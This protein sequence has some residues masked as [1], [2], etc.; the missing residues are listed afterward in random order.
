MSKTKNA[1]SAPLSEVLRSLVGKS[2]SLAVLYE[3]T[4]TKYV[5][6]PSRRAARL[7]LCENI[8]ELYRLLSTIL[9][10]KEQRKSTLPP[11]PP[12]QSQEQRRE[13]KTDQCKVAAKLCCCFRILSKGETF[14][15]TLR[16]CIF[17]FFFFYSSIAPEYFVKI[18]STRKLV[19]IHCILW[20]RSTWIS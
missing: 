1:D 14:A 6:Q 9:E 10:Q 19:R 2:A 17:S 4:E 13:K 11:P 18:L 5:H 16:L 8:K 12:T 20:N 7:Q 15:T 3:P